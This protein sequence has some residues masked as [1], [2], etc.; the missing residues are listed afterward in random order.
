MPSPLGER[1]PSDPHFTPH[2]RLGL[3]FTTIPE[4][5]FRRF[6]SKLAFCPAHLQHLTETI[7]MCVTISV[8]VHVLDLSPPVTIHSH[9]VSRKGTL[10]TPRVGGG[11]FSVARQMH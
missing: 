5:F 3:R 4:S 10:V 2:R 1:T 8:F 9:G 7:R 6:Y 11:L